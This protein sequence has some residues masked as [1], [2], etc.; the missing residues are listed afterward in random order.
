MSIEDDLFEAIKYATLG[1]KM[2]TNKMIQV[3]VRNI[4]LGA[5]RQL[6]GEIDKM[7]EKLS[8]QG[9]GF[10][11]MESLDPYKILGVS[12]DATQEEV[13]K[14]YRKKAAEAHPDK[15]GSH[16]QMI[17]VNAAMEAIRRFKGWK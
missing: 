6:R 1:G 12:P 9:V 14:A 13:Q 2:P 16:E 3:L 8:K 7:I 5:L 10:A 11:D 4:Q 17:K 15:G